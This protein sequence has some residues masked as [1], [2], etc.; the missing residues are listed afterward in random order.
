MPVLQNALRSHIW[1]K[2]SYPIETS[3]LLPI[4]ISSLISEGGNQS[5][6]VF[7]P[8]L[9]CSRCSAGCRCSLADPEPPWSL[10]LPL[11]EKV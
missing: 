4:S 2:F 7:A 3:T 5:S 8:L 9:L 11:E 10:P 1:Q 6:D